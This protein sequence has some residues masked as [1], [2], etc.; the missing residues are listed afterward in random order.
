M[1]TL[2]NGLNNL[3][4]NNMNKETLEEAAKGYSERHQDVSG[5]LG[6]YLV[7]AVFQDGAKW[8]QERMYSEE[9]LLNFTKYMLSK[10][11]TVA[12]SISDLEEYLPKEFQLLSGELMINGKELISEW[13]EQFKKK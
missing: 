7:S 1:I 5:N 10:K 4:T 8:A 12:R 6:K 3:K 13:F 9:E 2:I 11:V